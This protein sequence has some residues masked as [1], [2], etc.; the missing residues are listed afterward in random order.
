M[1][2]GQC[3]THSDLHDLGLT[4]DIR[5]HVGQCDVSKDILGPRQCNDRE[6]DWED[7][8]DAIGDHSEHVTVTVESSDRT[9]SKWPTVGQRVLIIVTSTGIF[10]RFVSFCGC[11]NAPDR[12]IQL[13]R[14]GL[15]PAT[16]LNPRTAFTF[17]VLDH[18]RLDTLECNM[19]ALAFM[20]KLVRITN[21]VFPS[22][23]LVCNI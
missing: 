7:V 1:F 12:H 20:S 13:L 4:I 23:V 16:F 17:E 18:F 6:S 15:F 21:E 11:A 3:Y 2:T 14:R 8:D 10:K 19:A 22:T 5:P 9:K